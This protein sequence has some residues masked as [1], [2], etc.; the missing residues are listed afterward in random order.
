MN[1][2]FVVSLI[3]QSIWLAIIGGL[4]I[5]ATHILK[6]RLRAGSLYIGLAV[7]TLSFVAISV[8]TFNYALGNGILFDADPFISYDNLT[9]MISSFAAVLAI[10][11]DRLLFRNIAKV[12]LVIWL[13]G[14]V[15][16]TMVQGYRFKNTFKFLKRWSEPIASD[17]IID[18]YN[19]LLKE[20][21]IS[22]KIDIKMNDAIFT[23][24]LYGLRK[25]LIILPATI[26]SYSELEIEL[27]LRHEL[28]HYIR[29]D[30]V[31]SFFVDIVSTLFWWNPFV[32]ML[33][34]SVSLYCEIS[35]DE[36]VLAGKTVDERE[37]Y[38]KSIVK[39]INSKARKAPLICGYSSTNKKSLKKRLR[40]IG[41]N[42]T[43]KNGILMVIVI[44][45]L[46][47]FVIFMG[48]KI[49]AIILSSYELYATV[50]NDNNTSEIQNTKLL[51]SASLYWQYE[52]FGMDF[53]YETER[54]YLNG[55]LVRNFE[56]EY[57]NFSKTVNWNND[58][59]IDVFA[60]RD[61][62]NK[63]IG[64]EYIEIP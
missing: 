31:V 53:D 51:L 3:G 47:I 37:A 34:R 8:L 46:M 14:I 45:V 36:S 50:N 29:K 61:S 26:E 41:D 44:S 12:L 54:L 32:N 22:S 35:C 43:R 63:L 15:F 49:N 20:K 28:T 55:S 39:L 56:D 4:F 42:G 24:L 19:M 30:Y 62:D 18:I 13:T 16:K 1:S 21:N 40:L 5:L 38:G 17:K 9:N 6:R 33:R 57:T 25:P 23:P 48:N 52:E 27:I 60:I 2:V 58:G 59:V 7:I 64:L 10:L 11:I